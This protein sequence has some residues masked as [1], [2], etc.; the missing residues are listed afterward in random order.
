LVVIDESINA[1]D[2]AAGDPPIDLKVPG[3]EANLTHH[4]F[5]LG[6]AFEARA[7]GWIL[8]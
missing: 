4:T 7:A 2:A 6:D 1:A 8:E 5:E 3:I